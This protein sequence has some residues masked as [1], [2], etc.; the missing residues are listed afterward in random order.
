MTISRRTSAGSGL[1]ALVLAAMWTLT[2]GG[3]VQ[4]ADLR[5]DRG[6]GCRLAAPNEMPPGA[7]HWIG[8]CVAG[9]ADGPGVVRVVPAQ[10]RRPVNFYGLLKAGH[11]V[12]G[13]IDDPSGGWRVG[14]F[15]DGVL[16]QNRD[17]ADAPFKQA[18]A[19]V[20]GAEL[21][22]RVYAAKGNA[23]SAA[24]YRRRAATMDESS[25]GGH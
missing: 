16:V 15:R 5:L 22:A 11:P 18:Q 19:A 10:G 24:Y 6:S 4:A 2:P 13:W 7:T 25:A 17:D 23:A 1:A 8:A 20:Q 21:A 3:P 12:R 14:D 9:L